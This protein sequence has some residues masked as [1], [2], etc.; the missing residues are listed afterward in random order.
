[1]SVLECRD[2][3][4]V[5]TLGKVTVPALKGVSLRFTPGTTLLRGP[6]GSGKS[7]LLHILGALDTPTSGDLLLDGGSIAY[8][9]DRK[10]TLLRRSTIGF[11]FQNFSLVGMLNVLDNVEYPLLNNRS[12]SAK[13]RRERAR[14]FIRQ[15]GL[16]EYEKRFPRELSGGQMQRVAIARALVSQPRIIL[17]DEP[18]ANL[19]SEAGEKVMTLLTESQ[20]EWETIMI[21]ASHD[22]RVIAQI[23]RRVTLRDGYVEEDRHE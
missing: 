19:D 20:R 7:T 4:K 14:Y 5:Y 10:K 8:Y 22:D 11:I 18:T 9:P 1:M 2:I 13:E 16:A 12:V 23:A 6:S 17:A 3:K 21:I 15:V